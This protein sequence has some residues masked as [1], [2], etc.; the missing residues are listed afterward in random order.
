MSEQEQQHQQQQQDAGQGTPKTAGAWLRDA[1]QQRGLHIAAVAAMLKVPQAK[2]EALEADRWQELTDMTFVRALAKAVCRTLKIDPEPVLQLL[3]RGGER[4]LDVNKGINRPFRERGARD[5]GFSLVQLRRPIFWGPAL[6]LVAAAVL[7][8]MPNRLLEPSSPPPAP[9]SAA[10]EVAVPL[11]EAPAASEPV[12]AETVLAPAPVAASAVASAPVVVAAAASLPKPAPAPAVTASAAVASGDL[13]PL[14]LHIKAES[15]VAVSDARGQ[16][17]I[18]RLVQPGE[19]PDLAGQPPLK[20]T[21]GNVAGTE[22]SVR[23][24]PV[25]LAARN[26]DNVARFELN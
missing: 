15:W 16:V 17:L 8:L 7:Y 10:S 21:I 23:G 18:S 12:V 24:N 3:P 1:R 26:K 19:D 5:D 4:E 6:L 2:L 9:T 22:L 20:V 25:D 11:A 13:L 14:K